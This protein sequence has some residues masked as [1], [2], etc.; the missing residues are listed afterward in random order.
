MTVSRIVRAVK[1]ASKAAFGDWRTQ[2]AQLA[3]DA[4]KAGLRDSTDNYKRMNGGI[5]VMKG[6]GLYDKEQE[7]HIAIIAASLPD[8]I[9]LAIQNGTIDLDDYPKPPRELQ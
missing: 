3:D 4:I 1:A 2:H 5:Q 9:K 7:N 6:L 8:D